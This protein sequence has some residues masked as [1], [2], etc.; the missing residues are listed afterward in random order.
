MKQVDQVN[1]LI[2]D[3]I[4]TSDDHNICDNIE[5]IEVEDK[6]TSSSES[7]SETENESSCLHCGVRG[8]HKVDGVCWRW[9]H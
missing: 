5:H 3:Q 8:V 6:E 4:I 2:R 1:S 7:E 9:P